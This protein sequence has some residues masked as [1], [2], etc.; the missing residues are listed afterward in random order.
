MNDKSQ[1]L[2]DRQA[3]AAR[4]IERCREQIDALD[5]KLVELLNRRAMHA[6]EIGRLKESIGLDTYQPHREVVVL[7]QARGA[8]RGPLDAGAITRLFERVIDESRRLERLEKQ[9]HA[10]G[11]EA[12]SGT[13][14]KGE[15]RE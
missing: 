1:S 10:A 13:D 12:G 14:P 15:S 4:R 5:A 7:E 2:Q 8:N 9:L 11:E 6:L 3:D